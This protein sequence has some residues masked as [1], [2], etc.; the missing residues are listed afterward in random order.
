MFFRN[1]TILMYPQHKLFG[2]AQSLAD[3]L[4]HA[5][6]KP[7]GP[8]EMA[9]RG[10][11]PPMGR[12]TEELAVEHDGAFWL[13]VGT[14]ERLLPP[15]VVNDAVAAKLESIEQAEGRRPGGRERK[16]IKDDLLHEMMPRAF[17]KSA[18]TDMFLDDWHGFLL[19]DTAT[20]KTADSIASDVRGLLGSFPAMSINTEVAPRSILT[21]WIAGEPMPAGLVLGEEC[22]LKDPADGGAV[23]RCRN[24][25]LRSDEINNHLK[26][27]KQ[28]ARLALVWQ[29][30]CSFELDDGLTIRKLRF[31]DGA[32]DRLDGEEG[33]GRHAELLARFALQLGELRGLIQ[34]L[35]QAFQITE[36]V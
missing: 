22:E 28:V 1:C 3:A 16:R 29:D 10:F 6:L 13:A 19:V 32:M 35:G 20:R 4:P 31:L 26:A 9:S 2:L 30:S 18:R 36:V 15:S 23:V 33:E 11:I 14:N 5:A 27:G 12:T 8:L 21:S 34:V 17:V 25:E 7:V 24:Q